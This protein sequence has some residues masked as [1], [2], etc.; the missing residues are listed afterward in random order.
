MEKTSIRVR[1]ETRTCESSYKRSRQRSKQNEQN[2]SVLKQQT[3][4]DPD[5]IPFS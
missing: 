4:R 1:L 3:E 5:K 2:T